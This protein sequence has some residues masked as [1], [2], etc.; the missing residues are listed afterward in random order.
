MATN[1]LPMGNGSSAHVET[2]RLDHP[3]QGTIEVHI[4]PALVLQELDPGFPLEEGEAEDSQDEELEKQLQKL[5][6]GDVPQQVLITIDGLPVARLKNLNNARVSLQEKHTSQLKFGEHTNLVAAFD[7]PRLQLD[8]N[9]ISTWM[10]TIVFKAEGDPGVELDPPEGSQA[11]KRYAAMAAS[12]WKRVVFPLTAGLGKGGSAL[13]IIVLGPL[14]VA[15]IGRIIA[16]IR[17]LLPEWEFSIP[18]PEVNI[19]WPDIDLS[20]PQWSLPAFDPPDWLLFLVEYSK[21]WIPVFLGIVLGGMAVRRYRKSRETKLRWKQRHQE[22]GQP[23]PSAEEPG[24]V[25]DDADE[26]LDDGSQPNSS[27]P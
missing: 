6:L 8:S 9:F 21:V 7:Q 4:G 17:E 20:W 26:D 15:L 23:N 13:A 1:H 2:W 19:P 22:I 11:A 18:W 5:G 12:P 3:E 25:N 24:D 16:W 14:I 10:R 27:R